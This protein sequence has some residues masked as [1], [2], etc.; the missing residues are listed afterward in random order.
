[1]LGKLKRL[2]PWWLKVLSK[3]ILARLPVPHR[4][5]KRIGLFDNGPMQECAYADSVYRRHFAFGEPPPGYACLEL[6]PGDTL[7]SAIIGSYLGAKKTYLVDAA[8]CATVDPDLYRKMALFLGGEEFAVAMDWTSLESILSGYHAVYL[9][10][11]LASLRQIP[12]GSID[13]AF[14][15]SVLQHVRKAEFTE[16]LAELRRVLAPGAYCSNVVSLKDHMGGAL[17]NLRFPERLWESSMFANSGFYTN[18]IRF[19]E[20]LRRFEAAGL[21]PEVIARRTWERLPTSRGKMCQEF[22]ALPDEDLLV[23]GFTVVLRPAPPGL[24]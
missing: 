6:G 8:L 19:G 5:W 3:L 16:L 17:N 9:T 13:F 14:S 15:Q 23:S 22:K 18:R 11:G 24:R 4:V 21:V 20:M 1:M 10:G 12:D 7:F 2:F